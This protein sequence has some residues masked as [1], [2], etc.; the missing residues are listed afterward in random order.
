MMNLVL[1]E[2]IGVCGQ[3]IPWNFPLLMLIWKVGPALACGCTLVL[4]VGRMLAFANV[5]LLKKRL[6]RCDVVD[7]REDPPFRFGVCQTY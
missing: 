3:I 7:K 2:P 4:K 5:L 1:K 6:M